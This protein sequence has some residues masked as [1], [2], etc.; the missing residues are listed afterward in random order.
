MGSAESPESAAPGLHQH[1]VCFVLPALGAGGSEHVVTSVASH[2]AARGARVSVLTFE[3]PGT[4]PYYALRPGVELRQFGL[5]IAP[6]GALRAAADVIGRVLR[7]RRV[8]RAQRPDLVISFLTR[9]NV[10]AVLAAT[11]LGIPVVVSERN[12]PALQYPGRLWDTLRR[13]TYRRAHGLV[14][15]THGAMAHF[16]PAMRRRSW[17]IPNMADARRFARGPERADKVFAAVGR[18]HPQK[19]FD[20]LIAAFAM[21]APHRPDWTLRIWGEGAERAALELQV[22]ALGLGD[23]IRLPGVS[24]QPGSWIET[25]DAFVLSSRFEGWGLVLGEAMA[26]GLPCVSFDCHWGPADMIAPDTGGLL[27][28]D[29]DVTA[30]AQAMARLMD[31]A[32]LRERLGAAARA[33]MARFAPAAIMARWEELVVAILSESAQSA[34]RAAAGGV[35]LPAAGKAGA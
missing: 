15:M 26:A 4:P 19:G 29:G 23:R 7:L 12:N 6:R 21:I 35:L 9:T 20:L 14:T 30:L 25:A 3:Q 8:L 5:P 28:P 10:I 27:V 33:S 34:T 22:A 17:V 31:D 2:L 13:W 1:H 32:G 11:G 18:L 16:P 24:P